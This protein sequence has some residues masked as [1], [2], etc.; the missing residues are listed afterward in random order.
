VDDRYDL[1]IVGAGVAGLAAASA[2]SG[3]GLRVALV[4][5]RR[6]L[7]G[8]VAGA[9]G[10]SAERAEA[11][12]LTPAID[13]DG[14]GRAE[15]ERLAAALGTTEVRLDAL[16]WGLFPGFLAAVSTGGRTERLDASQVLLAT[17]EAPTRPTF[18]GHEMPG[19]VTPVELVRRLELGE[20]QPGE[21]VAVLGSGALG[22]ACAAWSAGR[23][24]EVAALLSERPAPGSPRTVEL[25]GPP[26]ALGDG[27]L[28]QVE[29]GGE[30]LDVD[31]LCVTEPTSAAT[32]LAGM[33]GCVLRFQGYDAGFRP[34]HGPDGRTAVPGLWVAGSLTGMTTVGDAAASGRVAGTAAA[35]SAGAAAV[36]ALEDALGRGL[37][38][39]APPPPAI[40]PVTLRD[41]GPDHAVA[42]HCTGHAIA[43]VRAAI[44]AGARSLDDV[45][46]QAKAGMG[47]C[48]GR[49]CGRLVARLLELEAGVDI[50]TLHAM[51]PRPPA[52]PLPARA[53]YAGEVEA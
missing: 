24:L 6:T 11:C 14:A 25:T 44:R 12:W 20:A 30:T 4:D 28:R 29:A 37:E 38:P 26:R 35:V 17:G 21:R 10:S 45:K 52:R 3:H 47:I 36:G 27:R 9:L 7:G 2:A 33:V 42:C 32:E 53:M 22:R 16:V 34:E 48:Q 31:W 23:G 18:P 13:D 19:V 49:D 41:V 39:A 43:D 8:S 5:E 40:V 51:R 46:R 15:V 50:A 1:L